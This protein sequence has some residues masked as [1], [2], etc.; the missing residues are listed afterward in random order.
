[1][2]LFICGVLRSPTVDRGYWVQTMARR[3]GAWLGQLGAPFARSVV[4]YNTSYTSHIDP[5]CKHKSL[6]MMLARFAVL[7]SSVLTPHLS[8]KWCLVFVFPLLVFRK[9]ST[10]FACS[11]FCNNKII[12]NNSFLFDY[13][14]H[15]HHSPLL[16]V[17]EGILD[18]I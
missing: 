11:W 10:F 4:C 7:L 2:P 3:G 9:H 17:L 15:N 1:M 18:Y 14:Y 6:L 13:I 16:Y 12:N 8:L 5:F